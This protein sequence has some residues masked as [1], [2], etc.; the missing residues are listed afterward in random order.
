MFFSSKSFPAHNNQPIAAVAISSDSKHIATYSA[1]DNSLYIWQSTGVNIFNIGSN[2][3][4]QVKVCSAAPIEL[5]APITKLASLVWQ[6]KN[7]NLVYHDGRKF[8]YNL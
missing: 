7:L 1:H 4:K 5:N 3:L 2:S 8:S 6:A